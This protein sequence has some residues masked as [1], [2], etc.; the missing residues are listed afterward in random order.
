MENFEEPHC[1]LCLKVI[2]DD[3]FEEIEEA[4]RNMF[5]FLLLNLDF[6]NSN[7]H[8]I[9]N[10]C[11]LQ[12]REAYEFKSMCLYTDNTIIPHV[13]YETECSV[14][15]REIYI[16]ET[17]DKQLMNKLNVDHKV[18]RLCMQ[19]T[20][21][22]F[23]SIHKLEVDMM[24]KYI[25]EIN[26][27]V[28]KDPI[29]CKRCFVSFSTHSGFI[30][31]CLKIKE[32]VKS[33]HGTKVTASL[34][35]TP[36]LVSPVKVEIKIKSE[37]NE[38]ED[39][40][41]E[42]GSTPLKFE[43]E[44]MLIK[45]EPLDIK[46]EEND[47]ES[48]IFPDISPHELEETVEISEVDKSIN[49]FEPDQIPTIYICDKCNFQSK[50]KKSFI[51]HQ[52]VHKDPSALHLYK[53]DLCHFES[54]YNESFK[55][56]LAKHANGATFS[57]APKSLGGRPFQC[58]VCKNGYVSKA[59]LKIHM[60][61]H[62]NERPFVCDFCGKAFRQSGDL[63][64]HKRLH[65]TGK[66]IECSVCQKRFTTVMKL[67]YHMRNHTGERP[68]VCT[69]C[70]RGFTVNTILL[71][72]MRVH[73]GERPYV[74]VT[75]GKAFSQSSTLNTHMKVHAPSLK[76]NSQEQQRMPK[77]HNDND[78]KYPSQQPQ[79]TADHSNPLMQNDN[80]MLQ[81]EPI[82]RMIQSD[83]SRMLSSDGSPILTDSSQH[84]LSENRGCYK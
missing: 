73:S 47:K 55:H 17:E 39:E 33:V 1:R 16:K 80:R 30:Q 72:H 65:G 57:E 77:F 29:I 4:T 71:R 78:E 20:N 66:P 59:S 50:H 18:C 6:D 61:I 60:R 43:D 11:S 8:I 25:P 51:G 74:C 84:L 13:D 67:K 34:G 7:K 42:I 23:M 19:L 21:S 35:W 49:Q 12:V 52:I 70:G 44:E 38:Q 76:Y 58:E 15:L 62:T 41:M 24:E 63:T 81:T 27:S 26:F 53:W 37:L 75:C 31:K 32:N 79:Q 40:F 36:S 54:K 5:G 22:E 14:D 48:Y 10:D 68:Y 46:A 3:Q 82:Q 69:V 9:C 56:H 28:V 45:S 64:S 83:N 2:S